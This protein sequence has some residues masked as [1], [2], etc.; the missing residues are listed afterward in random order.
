LP[1]QARTLDAKAL[2]QIY[3]AYFERLYRYA[4]HF[5]ESS[6]VEQVAVVMK[7]IEEYSNAE[8]GSLIDKP[9]G[10]IKSLQQRALAALRKALGKN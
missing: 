4:F 6:A 7:F 5:V 9:D 1:D 3:D 8:I 10:A 2:G